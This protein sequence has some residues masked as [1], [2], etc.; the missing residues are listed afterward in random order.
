MV[1]ATSIILYF[2]ASLAYAGN[3]YT[4]SLKKL[5]NKGLAESLTVKEA[6]AFVWGTGISAVLFILAA[7]LQIS[8]AW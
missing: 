5:P 1:T 6:K 7:G 3:I 4:I 2:I 8:V